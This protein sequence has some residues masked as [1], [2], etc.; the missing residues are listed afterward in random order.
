MADAKEPE[1]LYYFA[2]GYTPAGHMVTKRRDTLAGANAALAELIA[3][4]C[5]MAGVTQTP[6]READI[7]KPLT[8]NAKKRIKYGKR[9]YTA[10]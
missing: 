10:G 5:K 8:N 6:C 7:R 1:K 2:Y 9:P 3:R 4:K